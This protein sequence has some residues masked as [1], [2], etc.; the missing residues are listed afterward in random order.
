VI[1]DKQILNIK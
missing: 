1:H